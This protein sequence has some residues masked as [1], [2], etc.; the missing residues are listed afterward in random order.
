MSRNP[1]RLKSSS[2]TRWMA[3][4]APKRDS[5]RLETEVILTFMSCSRLMS[6]RVLVDGVE[7]ARALN[8]AGRTAASRSALA[9][10]GIRFFM[11]VAVVAEQLGATSDF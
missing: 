2:V 7:S 4:G 1:E 11:N 8:P 5:G 3:A 9:R 10:A 6:G